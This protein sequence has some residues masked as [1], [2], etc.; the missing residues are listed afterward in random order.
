MNIMTDLQMALKKDQ[1]VYDSLKTFEFDKDSELG[2]FADKVDETRLVE[3]CER[4]LLAWG[5]LICDLRCVKIVTGQKFTLHTSNK[6]ESLWAM[7]RSAVIEFFL[8]NIGHNKSVEGI[9]VS[10]ADFQ[11]I[12]DSF[13]SRLIMSTDWDTKQTTDLSSSEGSAQDVDFDEDDMTASSGE[14]LYE[15]DEEDDD[16]EQEEEQEDDEEQ[17]DAEEPAD[18]P[19]ESSEKAASSEN[20]STG[21]ENNQ[22]KGRRGKQTR[23][24]RRRK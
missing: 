17:E 3:A 5:N 19:Q 21:S 14:E 1:T 6:F 8:Y 12:V 22:G 18:E 4:L 2:I 23:V 10:S 13:I 20:T 9:K 16:E 15:D 7:V 11:G 24:R